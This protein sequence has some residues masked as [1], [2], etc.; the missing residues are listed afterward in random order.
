MGITIASKNQELKFE[1]KEVINIGSNSHC[2]VKLDVGFELLLTLNYN[3]KL[4]KCIL[5]NTLKSD[6]VLFRGQPLPQKLLIE[7]VCKV[8]I[9]G[10]D[11]FISI[12]ID[13]VQNVQSVSQAQKVS[14]GESLGA[15]STNALHSSS[16]QKTMKMIQEEDFTESDI[17]SIYGNSINAEI[18]V[19]LEKRKADIEKARVSIWKEIGF[20]IDDLKKRLDLNNRMATAANIGIVAIP[21]LSVAILS[22]FFKVAGTPVSKGVLIPDYVKLLLITAVIVVLLSLALKQGLFLYM[23][24]KLS[25]RVSL[26]LKIAENS[27]LLGSGLGYIVLYVM[28]TSLYF[29]P[30]M[31]IPLQVM[32]VGSFAV[33]LAMI[34]SMYCGYVKHVNIGLEVEL[35]KH[36]SREDFQ[37]VI[38]AYRHWINLYVNNFSKTKIQNIKDKLFNFQ[39]KSVGET[40]LGILTAPF[41]AYG[42]SNTLAM[43][44]PEAAGWIRISGLRFSPIFLTLATFLII[45]AFFAFSLS[46]FS[47]RKAMASEVIKKDGFSNELH[48]GVDI[49]GKEGLNKV[50]GERLRWFSIGATI[51]FI[52][53]SMNVS[54]FI[55]E[56]G[57]DV[58]GIFLSI[59]AALVPTALLIAETYMLSETKFQIFSHEAII[60]KIDKDF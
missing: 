22:D 56:I 16:P 8:M 17:K 3:A 9:P 43:C 46:F 6:K 40:I 48:H 7:K 60:S 4:N 31:R 50:K 13:Q 45:F 52:E 32:T 41:L 14:V 51:I 19:K 47:T 33:G 15:N 5:V 36:E 53:F 27:F 11:E 25:H 55:T 42:V 26:P 12:R 21:F 35:D 58:N 54:Y 57:G 18:R 37:R 23:Q 34:S 44:F 20:F 2:D 24:N 49:Y 30:E 38:E 1:G 28:M 29:R 10:S 39:L 59:I